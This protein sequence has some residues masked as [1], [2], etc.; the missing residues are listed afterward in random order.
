MTSSASPRKRGQKWEWA[1]VTGL[2][3]L[4]L[5]LRLVALGRSPPGVRFDELV[6]VKMAD[7]IYAGEW[8]IYFQEA[9]GHEP[10]YHYVHAAG[11]S[12]LG[13]TVL[14]VR[15]A[16]I[17]FG[18]LGVLA[19][20]A[21]FR[22]LFGWRVALIAAALLAT[23]FWSLMYSRIGLRHISLPPWICLTAILFWRGLE[24]PAKQRSRVLLWFGLAGLCQG[25]L[26]YTYFASRAVPLL[27]GAFTLYLLFA[28][29][30]KL[31][32]RWWGLL[33]F[34]G[35][36]ALVVTPMV[37]Y[38]RQHP[39]LEQRLGQVGA[40]ILAG[41]RRG[42]LVPLIKSAWASVKMFSFRG[43]PEWLY[44]I[45]GRPVFDPLTS[46]LF[47]GG[48]LVS[49]WR[50][51][52]PQRAFLLLWLAAGISPT[53]VSWP[54][55]SLGHSIAAQPAVYAIPALALVELLHQAER[56]R[57][58]AG[59]RWL[60]RAALAAVAVV[61]LVFVSVNAYDYFVRWPR[62]PDVRHE[63]QA[64]ITAV[65]R[66]VQQSE[67]PVD[68][69]VSAPYV[70]YWHPW[71]VWNY[72]LFTAG[73]RAASET[74][75][76]WFNGRDSLLFPATKDA[77][78][79]V[80]FILPDHIRLPSQLDPDLQALLTSGGR[81]L[82]RHSTPNGSTLDRYLWQ[83][84]TALDQ[85]LQKV[86]NAPVWAGPEGP[87]VAGES[88]QTRTAQALPLDFGSRLTLLGYD[89]GDAE[90]TSGGEWRV[91]TYWQVQDAPPESMH[92]P[93]AIFVHALDETNAV[94]LGW[95]GLHV[96][97]ENWW[98]GDV[99]IQIHTLHVPPH[100]SAGIY[101]V[102]LGVYSPVSLERLPIHTEPAGTTAPHNRLLLESLEVH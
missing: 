62:F 86:Q 60:Y 30:D 29:P 66:F 59:K 13:K 25:L 77:Q 6:N 44:N 57:W 50:W 20:Y 102:E 95:D 19:A 80:L 101:R 96:S 4:A 31:R 45:S 48:L 100:V 23:S 64:P 8:P 94:T 93:L 27:F 75:V 14:G 88:E 26:L 71:S 10:L 12:L 3:V 84:R 9:W 70:D 7:H 85:R 47:Y 92:A 39:E 90:V 51:R 40:E 65:A 34:F 87:Y 38:L 55:G 83:D 61:S 18:V 91:A 28:H 63:Y 73:S 21:L 15:L 43:D 1:W 53:L 2:A 54:S 11:M 52:Q 37:L 72:D 82:G 74:R 58:A 98:T 69:A 76:R 5:L 42:D 97:V 79:L 78:P 22:Q 81:E 89:Y 32:G 35:L 46:I 33:L 68:V 67:I 99:V 49:L 41:L 36:T 17:L 24:T 16:S 56:R